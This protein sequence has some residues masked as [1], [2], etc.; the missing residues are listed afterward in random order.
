MDTRTGSQLSRH[1]VR[2]S[3]RAGDAEGI[4]DLHRRVYAREFGLG[5]GFVA[6]VAA[7]IDAAVA[8]GW[9]SEAGGVWLIDG[10][11]RLS[12]SLALTLEDDLVGRVRWF[13]LEPSLRGN[14]CG[15]SLLAELLALAHAE[16]LRRL[17][18]E[19]FSALTAA[20]HLY[21]RAGFRLIWERVRHDWGPPVTYQGYELDLG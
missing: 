9:P 12:G 15:A 16:G 17:E 4:A 6:A 8:G 13:V 1:P 20:A 2:R 7:G 18:L 3:L 10:A 19:T 11:G 5:P 21:R 14:G